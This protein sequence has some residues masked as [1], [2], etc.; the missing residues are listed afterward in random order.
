MHATSLRNA[1]AFRQP[2]EPDSE[3]EVAEAWGGDDD[4]G[5]R[6][7]GADDNEAAASTAALDELPWEG[8]AG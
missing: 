5:S 4:A 3:D 7:L 8:G 6:G 1:P 2:Y